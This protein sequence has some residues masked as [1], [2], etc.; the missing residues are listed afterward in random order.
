MSK[1]T[2]GPWKFHFFGDAKWRIENQEGWLIAYA[3]GGNNE[4][5]KANARL[6]AAAPGFAE[7][8]LAL[9][10]DAENMAMGNGL[11]VAR[12]VKRANKRLALANGDDRE[13]Q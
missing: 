4:I 1:W 12:A 10:A 6:I 11:V 5:D 2:P 3:R 9:I 13:T 7:D 8:A